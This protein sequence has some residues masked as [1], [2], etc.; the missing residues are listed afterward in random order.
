MLTGYAQRV[1][2]PSLDKPVY[3]AG[4][5]ENR[6]ALAVH[7]DLFARALALQ[8]GET[9]LVLAALDLIAF[10]RHEAQDVQARLPGAQLILACTHNHHGPD[11]IGMWGKNP[12]TSGVDRAYMALVKDALTAAAREALERL[13]PVV[14]RA[15][16]TQVPGLV[17][18]PRNPDILDQELTCAQFVDPASGRPLATLLDFPCHPE[19][20]WFDNRVITADYPGVLRTE[21]ETATGAPCIFFS[22]ALGGMMT[23]DVQDHSFAEAETMGK[24]LAAAALRTLAPLSPAPVKPFAC[25]RLDFAVPLANP[26]F[27]LGMLLGTLP[28]LPTRKGELTTQVGLLRLGPLGLA[29]VPGELLPALGL[30]IKARLRQAGM[31][32]PA[33]IGLAND[34]IGYIIPEADFLY[35][36]NPLKPGAHYEETN[37]MGRETA[38]RL[39]AA[40]ERLM[41]EES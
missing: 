22:G 24:T 29:C 33:V 34:E 4:L 12:F 21:V 7:D 6:T 36:R 16:N 19:V 3:L 28:R 8:I 35:P 2:T 41:A 18:N 13:Q 39:M 27:K 9:R 40:F 1:I 38:P 26:L 25:R 23:P 20:L 32:V 30:Q 15:A 31:S 11:T 14:L 10:F 17:K 37:S 5:G